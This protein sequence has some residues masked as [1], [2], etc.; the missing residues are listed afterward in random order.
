MSRLFMNRLTFFVAAA[1][2]AVNS[3]LSTV[4]QTPPPAQPEKTTL[5]S[6]TA[7]LSRHEGFVPYYWDAKKGDILFELSPAALQS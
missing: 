4:A 7:G 1:L 3:N 5:A 6:R 2:V